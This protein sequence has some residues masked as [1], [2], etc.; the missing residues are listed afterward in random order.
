MKK[1]ADIH[2]LLEKRI[3]LWQQDKF[4]LLLQ[5]A[6]RCDKTF[7]RTWNHAP[8]ED[9]IV[10]VS[11]WLV[12]QGKLKAAVRCSVTIRLVHWLY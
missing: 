1:A 11:S 9:A 4:D 6:E 8:N 12:L 10:W 7:Q 2:H 3:T 5:E